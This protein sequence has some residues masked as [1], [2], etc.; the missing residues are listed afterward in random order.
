M[1]IIIFRGRLS[2]ELAS[3]GRSARF[4]T[5]GH[6]RSG[7]DPRNFSIPKKE[8]RERRRIRSIA[9]SGDLHRNRFRNR[10]I[11]YLSRGIRGIRSE[12]DNDW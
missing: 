2:A 3:R 11:G 4:G 12:S 9:D 10:N 8:V 6:R 5:G 1:I 7:E